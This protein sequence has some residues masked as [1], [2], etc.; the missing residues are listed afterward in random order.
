[1]ITQYHIIL[2]EDYSGIMKFNIKQKRAKRKEIPE[3]IETKIISYYLLLRCGEAIMIYLMK[4]AKEKE[5]LYQIQNI[6]KEYRFI[7]YEKP[8]KDARN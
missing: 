5:T 8:I 7:K 1:M 3:I 2:W 4:A 6:F